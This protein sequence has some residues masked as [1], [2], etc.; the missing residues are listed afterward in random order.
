MAVLL[1]ATYQVAGWLV[2]HLHKRSLVCWSVG[3][4][5][6][7]AVYL[8]PPSLFSRIVEAAVPAAA[9]VC[10]GYLALYRTEPGAV[11][12]GLNVPLRRVGLLLLA[13]L[14]AAGLQAIR[15]F[16]DL[17]FPLWGEAR[18]LA[19]VERSRSLG[20]R[21]HFTSAGRKLLRERF[22]ATPREF[23]RAM[24]TAEPRCAFCR[25]VAGELP[26]TQ[27]YSD[28]SVLAFR[29]TNPQA[30]VH[31]LVIPRRHIASVAEVGPDDAELLASMVGAANRVARELGIA[32]AGYR[33]V[34]NQGA[35]AGQTV[36]HLHLHVLGGR[37]MSWP[38]G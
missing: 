12:V 26:A 20:A 29:D 22:G 35:G 19:L 33:L 11:L 10:V 36:Y 6:V 37:R 8:K 27:V 34:I 32:D 21:V 15:L 3:P 14:L 2:A 24:S 9:V 1:L 25:I 30:P 4:L 16:G 18:M 5:G 31:V 28:G 17:R 7:Q 38:P 13:A 23:L